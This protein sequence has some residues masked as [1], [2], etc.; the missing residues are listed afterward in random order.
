MKRSFTWRLTTFYGVAGAVCWIAAWK[1]GGEYAVP[2]IIVAV[3]T[4]ILA[5]LWYRA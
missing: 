5:A 4:W 1:I 3:G 2:L